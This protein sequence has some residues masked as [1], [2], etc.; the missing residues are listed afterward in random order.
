MEAIQLGSIPVY[1][2]DNFVE[3]HGIDFNLYGVKVRPD[4]LVVL[5]KI[6]ADVDI[7]QKQ[8]MV[9]DM[10]PMFTFQGNKEIIEKECLL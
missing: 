4:Q 9:K 1:I 3:P 2:S 7:K 10:W 6:L 8:L 5:H